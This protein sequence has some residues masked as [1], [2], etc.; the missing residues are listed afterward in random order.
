M[1]S[2]DPNA[3]EPDSSA[4]ALGCPRVWGLGF[5]GWGL[6]F[7]V[8]FGV[9]GLGS[10][11]WGFGF[12]VWGLGFRACPR[13]PCISIMENHMEKNMKKTWKVAFI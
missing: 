13:D 5:R 6:G 7:W 10:R 9:W 2:V 4:L 1:E 8:G 3:V 12:R 11:G